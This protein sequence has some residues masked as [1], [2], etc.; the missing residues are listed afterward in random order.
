MSF[1]CDLGAMNLD[2]SL[3]VGLVNLL[4]WGGPILSEWSGI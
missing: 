3:I 1:A 2:R 4:D